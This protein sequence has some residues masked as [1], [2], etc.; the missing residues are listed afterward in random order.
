M[1]GKKPFCQNQRF[2]AVWAVSG[3][4]RRMAC[5]LGRF[6]CEDFGLRSKSVSP[7]LKAF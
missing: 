3:N 5:A 7:A 4:M 1:N 2:T 6:F